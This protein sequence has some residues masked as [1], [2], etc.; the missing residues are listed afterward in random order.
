MTSLYHPRPERWPQFSLRG[1]LVVILL[2][3]IL[4]AKAATNFRRWQDS[5][6]PSDYAEWIEKRHAEWQWL[7]SYPGVGF[8]P[9]DPPD[10]PFPSG[11][12]LLGEKPHRSSIVIFAKTDQDEA[13]ARKLA[14]LFPEAYIHL[15][16]AIDGEDWGRQTRLVR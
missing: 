2:A 10:R 15:G 14:I 16:R 11:L 13:R 8:M 1:L 9:D 4:M 12:Q 7:M 6:P 3:A 5:R